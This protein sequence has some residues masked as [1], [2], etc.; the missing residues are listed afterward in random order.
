MC[1]LAGLYAYHYAAN[2]VDSAELRAIRDHMAARGPDGEGEWLSAD[3]RSGFGHR[4]LAIIDLSDRAAQPMASADGKAVIIFNG[5]IY[6]YPALRRQLGSEG[7]RVFAPIRDTEVLLHLYARRRRGDGARVC[8]ACSPSPSGTSAKQ[9]LLPGPRSLRHQAALLRRRRL[10]LPLRLPGQGAARR[11]RG[12]ARS[13]AGRPRRLP[14]VRQRA[15]ALHALSRYPRPA[16]RP[17]QW[18]DRGGPTRAAAV[19]QACRKSL[20]SGAAAPSAG[21]K[22]DAASA[23]R[24]STASRR[25]CW[26][27]S[28]SACFSPPASIPGRSS[29]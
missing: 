23:P 22:L 13:R 20:P 11:R 10:D 9:G 28:R 1:G 29:A 6:N 24:R 2:P 26:P 19:R 15:G 17:R 16:G 12:L 3:G 18:I 7:A 5:E 14:P 8:A 27:T 4:R 21:A 25:T